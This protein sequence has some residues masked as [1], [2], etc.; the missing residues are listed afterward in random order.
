MKTEL[1]KESYPLS[2]LQQGM[3]FH[4]LAAPA[5]GVDV[6][7]IFCR[8]REDL[9]IAALERAW[10]RVVDRQDVLRTTFHW[11]GLASPCQS[12]QS[13]AAIEFQ[14]SDWR[15]QSRPEQEKLF[16]AAL[17]NDR[18]RGF[19]LSE[20]PPNRVALFRL[21]DADYQ[22]LWTFHHLL[23]DGRAVV[24]VF[25]EVFAFYEAIVR[26]EDLELPPPLPYRDY[27][28]WLG[29]LDLS[30]AEQFWRQ[31]L[32]GF[33]APTPVSV[34]KI[35]ENETG[36]ENLPGEQQIGLTESVTAALKSLARKNGFTPN[37]LL[38]GAWALLLSRYSRENDVV[39]GAIR[40]CRR[41]DFPGGTSASD[42]SAQ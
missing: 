28:D 2:P 6:E 21:G 32:K 7:Q 36:L 8:L 23:F 26:G 34:A 10:Q 37:T 39:F 41:S 38:Q 1:K 17:Q 25:N 13:H 40:A 30:P 9:D 14:V 31:T 12:V 29:R 18:R 27:V 33:T 19:D 35:S 42:L 11:Q 3:L 22:M 24:M 5:S 15:A 4:K 16:E 20:N